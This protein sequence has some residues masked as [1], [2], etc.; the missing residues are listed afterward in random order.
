[1]RTNMKSSHLNEVHWYTYCYDEVGHIPFF[2]KHLYTHEV[3]YIIT[4]SQ[5][6]SL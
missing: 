1:M 4:T 5:T 3:S 6:P 2:G